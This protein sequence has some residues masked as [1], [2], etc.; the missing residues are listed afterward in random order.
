MSE[1]KF[2]PGPW[3]VHPRL[4]RGKE[5]GSHAFLEI[6]SEV[7]AFWV[8]HVQT[9]DDDKGEYAANAHLIA[10]APEMYSALKEMRE[11]LASCAE[12][13]CGTPTEAFFQSKVRHCDIVLAKAEGPK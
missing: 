1:T 5:G 7:S 8:A 12:D 11:V 2:T 9:F 6:G 4:W 10:A 13:T 3:E